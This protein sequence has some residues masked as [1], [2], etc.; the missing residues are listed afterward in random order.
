MKRNTQTNVIVAAS[1]A[2]IVGVQIFAH[3]M[4]KK[5]DAT[6]AE[7]EKRIAETKFE[8]IAPRPPIEH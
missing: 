8:I 3:R 7:G 2:I 4:S 6:I 1:T 5:L